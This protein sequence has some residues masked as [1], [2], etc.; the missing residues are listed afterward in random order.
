MYLRFARSFSSKLDDSEA[1][2]RAMFEHES[3]GAPAPPE[4]NAFLAGKKWMDVTV[5]MWREDIPRGLLSRSELTADGYPDWFLDR[6]L[7]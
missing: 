4:S 1:A 3:T 6:V 2:A 7:K 5:K